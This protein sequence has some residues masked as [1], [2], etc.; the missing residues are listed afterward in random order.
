MRFAPRAWSGALFVLCGVWLFLPL[1]ILL[2][3]NL[4]PYAFGHEP[5]GARFFQAWL[6]LRESGYYPLVL[7]GYLLDLFHRALL[8]IL[9]KFG[10]SPEVDLLGA[11]TLFAYISIFIHSAIMVLISGVVIF[12]PKLSAAVRAATLAT[13]ATLGYGFRWAPLRLLVPDYPLTLNVLAY[14]FLA[15]AAI[16]LRPLTDRPDSG[17]NEQRRIWS[18]ALPLGVLGAAILLL[19]PS[20]APWTLLLFVIGTV[21]YDRLRARWSFAGVTLGVVLAVVSGSWFALLGGSLRTVVSY[22]YA[23]V[24]ELVH[25][26]QVEPFFRLRDFMTPGTTYFL[27][28]LGFLIWLVISLAASIWPSHRRLRVVP[29]AALLGG[30]FYLYVLA[31]RPGNATTYEI[32]VYLAITGTICSIISKRQIRVAM[33]GMWCAVLLGQTVRVA[34]IGY[35]QYI[36]EARRTADVARAADRHARSFGLPILYAFPEDGPTAYDVFQSAESAAFKGTFH[37]AFGNCSREMRNKAFSEVVRLYEM[38]GEPIS[39]PS[40]PYVL[41]IAD[42]PEAHGMALRNAAVREALAR[43]R[44]CQQWQQHR[45]TIRVCLIPAKG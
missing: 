20:L 36:G 16:Q 30:V 17:S 33:M 8:S 15:I 23:V 26:G 4:P 28:F 7:V 19:K 22:S 37:C 29:S 2:K 1:M 9:I 13:A 42:V 24:E 45:H 34:W 31:K 5:I 35:P 25:V 18:R 27:P 44:N 21:G 6:P 43:G 10:V 11:M 14:M 32:L 38:I 40:T 41:M 3:L 39:L 12:H